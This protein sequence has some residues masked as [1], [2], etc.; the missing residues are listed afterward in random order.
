MQFLE[1]FTVALQSWEVVLYQVINPLMVPFTHSF[2]SM[3]ANSK[4]DSLSS[5]ISLSGIG[6]MT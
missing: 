1:S 2:T 4:Q 3:S 6:L 5:F